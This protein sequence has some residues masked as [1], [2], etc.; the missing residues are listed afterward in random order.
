MS[1]LVLKGYVLE[2]GDAG[3]GSR[4]FPGAEHIGRYGKL[5]SERMTRP[6]PF[7]IKID[8]RVLGTR[9]LVEGA[10][11]YFERIFKNDFS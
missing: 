10:W 6:I 11:R 7:G 4:V 1:H 2:G 3:R 9:E 5:C 8:G